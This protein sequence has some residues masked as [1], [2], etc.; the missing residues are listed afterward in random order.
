MVLDWG[1]ARSVRSRVWCPPPPF[2]RASSPTRRYPHPEP[3]PAAHFPIPTSLHTPGAAYKE[4]T[5]GARPPVTP[6]N[7]CGIKSGTTEPAFASRLARRVRIPS[8]SPTAPAPAPV[9]AAAAQALALALALALAPPPLSPSFRLLS[10]RPR[11]Q[12]QPQPSV[13]ASPSPNPRPC[14]NPSLALAL[15]RRRRRVRICRSSS[16]GA[17]TTA[18][19]WPS[20]T[21]RIDLTTRP[22]PHASRR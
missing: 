8:P 11:P 17:A 16:S 18:S 19:H 21:R 14:P 6:G 9:P 15:T 22:G 1:C 5:Q 10:P 2:A 20:R 13:C 4:T 12:P 3:Q 7:A